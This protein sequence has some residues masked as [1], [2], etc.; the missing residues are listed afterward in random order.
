MIS[1]IV[2]GQSK[3]SKES[4]PLWSGFTVMTTTSEPQHMTGSSLQIINASAYELGTIWAVIER[5]GLSLSEVRQQQ[6]VLAR[7]VLSY[8]LTSKNALM[9]EEDHF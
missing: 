8:C 4:I 5:Y 3:K 1:W 2:Y 7:N 9:E 6:D